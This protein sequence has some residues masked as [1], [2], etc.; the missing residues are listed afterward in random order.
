MRAGA[1]KPLPAPWVKG[2]ARRP[3]AARRGHGRP[4]RAARCPAPLHRSRAHTGR[5]TRHR[6]RTMPPHRGAG[7]NR[8]H[9]GLKSRGYSCAA[10]RS[11]R[12][13]PW[14]A[15][16]GPSVLRACARPARPGHTGAFLRFAAHGRQTEGPARWRPSRR[17]AY[18]A[19]ARRSAPVCGARCG[20]GYMLPAWFSPSFCGIS[21]ARRNTARRR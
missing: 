8:L 7:W 18:Q 6:A 10:L 20:Y 12:G 15:E 9:N 1:R 13:T 16:S 3:A 21:A 2:L 17:R 4:A 5:R 11:M 19:P 14:P